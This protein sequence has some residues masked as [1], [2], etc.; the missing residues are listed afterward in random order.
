MRTLRIVSK[1]G[2]GFER[3]GAEEGSGLLS[4]YEWHFGHGRDSNDSRSYTD[5]FP[6]NTH[7]W[8]H[9]PQQTFQA[10]TAAPSRQL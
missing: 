6:I 9:L 7:E 3:A 2:R 1:W 8:W 10:F 4:V 5:Q